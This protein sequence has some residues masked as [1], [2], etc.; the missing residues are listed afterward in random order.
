MHFYRVLALNAWNRVRHRGYTPP[1]GTQAPASPRASASCPVPQPPSRPVLHQASPRGCQ[2]SPPAPAWP[3][4]HRGGARAP[5]PA[6]LPLPRPPGTPAALHSRRAGESPA[7]GRAEARPSLA[8]AAALLLLLL[9]F[10]SP[11]RQPRTPSSRCQAP[12]ALL[13]SQ[14]PGRRRAWEGAGKEKNRKGSP[15]TPVPSAP[16][17]LRPGGSQRCRSA[18]KGGGHWAIPPRR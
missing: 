18:G 12:T 14:G 2:H 16:L 3:G 5:A 1:G 13:T 9:A 7:E 8:L 11:S 17:P 15:G 4:C 6:P 10:S